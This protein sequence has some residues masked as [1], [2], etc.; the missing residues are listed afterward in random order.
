VVCERHIR[1][2]GKDALIH[3]D[4]SVY[5]VPW[6]L[7]RPR[8]KVELRVTRDTVAVWTLGAHAQQLTVHQ[9]PARK[10]SWVVNGEHWDGLPGHTQPHA[11][12]TNAPSSNSSPSD[13]PS[14][15][16]WTAVQVAHRSLADYDQIRHERAGAR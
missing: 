10:G 1:T 3:F 14:A 9:R 7:V 16:S 6:R 4:A 15:P 13:G 2:V 11:G 5:S 8:E 12:P